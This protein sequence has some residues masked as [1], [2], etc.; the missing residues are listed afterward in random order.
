M[1]FTE[2]PA[3]DRALVRRCVEAA[4]A[5]VY[6]LDTHSVIGMDAEELQQLLARW[7]YTEGDPDDEMAVNNAMLNAWGYPL[8]VEARLRWFG[9]TS[10]EVRRVHAAWRRATGRPASGGYADQM[11]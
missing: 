10:A 5:G 2:L 9:P 8:R 3:G 7:P 6:G 1:A 11:E 4:A